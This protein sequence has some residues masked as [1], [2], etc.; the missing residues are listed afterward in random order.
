M[1]IVLTNVII[2]LFYIYPST[3]HSLI[4][5][6]VE[7]HNKQTREI[8]Y[9]N[10]NDEPLSLPLKKFGWGCSIGRTIKIDDAIMRRL[11]CYP[12]SNPTHLAH[13]STGCIKNEKGIQQVS[14]AVDVE[15]KR[16]VIFLKCESSQ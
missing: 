10:P 7:L 6:T 15:K 14:L 3:S 2:L 8:K 13:T 5:W 4:N 9:F 11:I 1:K 16:Y 12:M